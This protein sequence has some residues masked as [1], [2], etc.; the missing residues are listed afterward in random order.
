MIYQIQKDTRSLGLAYSKGTAQASE[1]F[2]TMQ[3]IYLQHEIKTIP[4]A[5]WDVFQKDF[6]SIMSTQDLQRAWDAERK[7]YYSDAFIRYMSA[8]YDKGALKC[9]EKSE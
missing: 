1:I 2:A 5:A 4:D 3:S 8:L 9:R 6:C 7:D